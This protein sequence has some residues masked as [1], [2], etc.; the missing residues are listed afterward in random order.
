MNDRDPCHLQ[1]S[2][3]PLIRGVWVVLGLFFVVLGAIG[4]VLPGWP[5]TPF[6]LVAVACFARSSPRLYDWLLE[7]RFFGPTIRDYREGRGLRLRVKIVALTF[8]T[9]FIGYALVRGIPAELY[10]AK[11]V[12]FLVALYGAYFLLR[13]PTAS[14]RER[15]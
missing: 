15:R 4:V 9:V 3:N 2:S 14:A 12:V 11:V 8:L 10:W 7:N 6:L 1:V 13:L 5:T